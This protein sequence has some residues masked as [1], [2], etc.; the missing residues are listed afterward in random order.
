[1]PNANRRAVKSYFIW[2]TQQPVPIHASSQKAAIGWFFRR[3]YENGNL[4]D[5]ERSRY[6]NFCI[7]LYEDG[8]LP[9]TYMD[10][11]ARLMI[12]KSRR[13]LAVAVAADISRGNPEKYDQYVADMMSRPLA[14]LMN[15]CSAILWK[16]PDALKTYRSH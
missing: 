10:L 3:E 4:I 12:G 8:V 7:Q 14:H 5:E 16:D 15:H 2:F 1:M 11:P 9:V 13:E 6:A